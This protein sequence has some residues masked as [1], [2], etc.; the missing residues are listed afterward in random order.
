MGR[1][2]FRPKDSIGEN[3]HMNML[4]TKKC[5]SGVLLWR[6]DIIKCATVLKKPLSEYVRDLVHEDMKNHSLDAEGDKM[7]QFQIAAALENRKSRV[8]G[9]GRRVRARNLTVD[10][11]DLPAKVRKGVKFVRGGSKDAR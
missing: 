9:T 10:V 5:F 4:D 3:E 8:K 11:I 1:G 7:L 6:E 2:V